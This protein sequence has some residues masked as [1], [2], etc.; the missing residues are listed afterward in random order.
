MTADSRKD[1]KKTVRMTTD[2]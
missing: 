2:N 1:Y